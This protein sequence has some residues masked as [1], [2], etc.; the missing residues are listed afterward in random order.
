MLAPL[1]DSQQLDSNQ[2]CTILRLPASIY[3]AETEPPDNPKVIIQH[4]NMD[5]VYKVADI[6]GKE[7]FPQI[8]NSHIRLQHTNDFIIR[9]R[10]STIQHTGR[11]GY[12]GAMSAWFA[13][14]T[15]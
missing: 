8:E 1:H 9:N 13:Y 12:E 10:I 7:E 15:S 6:L 11:K 2:F 14:H 4:S 3:E 5:Y